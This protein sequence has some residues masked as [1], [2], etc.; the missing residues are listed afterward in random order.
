MHKNVA[1]ISLGYFIFLLVLVAILDLTAGYLFIPGEMT[2]R[3]KSFV[4]SRMIKYN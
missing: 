1:L 2:V 4:F 3:A